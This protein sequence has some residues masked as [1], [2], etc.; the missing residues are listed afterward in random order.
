LK[1]AANYGGWMTTSDQQIGGKSTVTMKP[2]EDGA[3]GSKGALQIAGEIVPGAEFTWAG[4]LFHPGDSPEAA[5]NLSNKKTISFWAKGDGKNYALA[6]TT[7]SNAGQMPVIEPF[8]A[9]SAWKQYTFSLSDFKT[10]GHDI[11]GL[12]FAHAQ[13]P[14]KFEFEIDQVDIR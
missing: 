14:G 13:E 4:V 1:V 3:N 9:G 8:V 12:T 2:V 11:T 10:D 6:V 5:V 7:E